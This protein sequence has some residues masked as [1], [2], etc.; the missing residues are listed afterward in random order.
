M[1][2]IYLIRHAEAEGNLYRRIHGHYDSLVTEN[3]QK[4]MEAL[5]RRFESVP[6]DAVYSS[7]LIRTRTTAEVIRGPR[8]L[9]LNI[10]RELREIHMGSWEDRTWG[11]VLREDADTMDR[12][13]HRP[14]QWSVPGS[15]SF[16]DMHRRMAESITEIAERHTG[17]TVAIV[18]HGT[19]IRSALCYFSGRPPEEV[20]RIPHS[21]NTGVSLLEIQE[22]KARIAV[23]N[24]NSHLEH[25]ISTFARQRWWKNREGEFTDQNLWYRP[26]DPEREAGLYVKARQDAWELVHGGAEGFRG[27]AHLEDALSTA[28]RNPSTLLCAMLGEEVAGILQIDMSREDVKE[29]GGIP[30]YYMKPEYRGRGLGVQLIGQ[31]ISVSRSRGKNTLRLRVAPENETAVRFY[32]KYGFR[33]TGEEEGLVGRLFV[34]EKAIGYPAF[35][36]EADTTA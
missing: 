34:M 11:E 23:Q 24:D 7:D 8:K 13:V 29:V 30:F 22:G 36:A 6:I 3:G 21:D 16:L 35:S 2:R 26:L 28:K 32:Q 10:K 18:S 5:G 33:K 31:A 1:T 17:E 12:F 4:Q 27:E 25:G 15:E 20:N 9:P 19:A 14:F